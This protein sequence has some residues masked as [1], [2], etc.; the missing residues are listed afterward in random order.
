M[1]K[2]TI[3]YDDSEI[4]E[5]LTEL[6]KKLGDLRE[7]LEEIGQWMLASTDQNFEA[8]T[9]PYGVPWPKNTPWTRA[10]KARE[11]FILKVLQQRGF[12]R[13]SISYKADEKSVTVGTNVE[14]A[15]QHQLGLKGLP[16]RQFIGIGEDDRREI[17]RILEEYL[18]GDRATG[19]GNSPRGN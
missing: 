18:A 13:R 6:Q 17:V 4:R 2:I 8:E 1:T 10:K 16:K 7:P 15:A 14:Y 3:E 11:G 12:L 5:M 19:S 9:D